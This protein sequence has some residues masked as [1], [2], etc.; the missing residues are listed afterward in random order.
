MLFAAIQTMHKEYY[1][2]VLSISGNTL[3]KNRHLMDIENGLI[4]LLAT[5]IALL[6]L[7]L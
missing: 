3:L 4:I 1:D 7:P 2:I 6:F 5:V